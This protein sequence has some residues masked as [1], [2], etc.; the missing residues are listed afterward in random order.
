M[1]SGIA[2]LVEP[3]LLILISLAYEPKHGYSIMQDV[4]SLT[5]WS[6]R[7]GTLYGA[8]GRMDRRGWIEE[9]QTEDY[10][11]RPYALTAGGREELAR[12]LSVLSNLTRAGVKRSR[13]QIRTRRRASR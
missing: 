13:R 1:E 2:L 6:M 7:A 10:R 9:I 12:Q 11:R 8:L 5:G 3:A 4:E